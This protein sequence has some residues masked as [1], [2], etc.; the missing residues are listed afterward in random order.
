MESYEAITVLL[1]YAYKEMKMIGMLETESVDD[2]ASVWLIVI[3]RDNPTHGQYGATAK[4]LHLFTHISN[5]HIA[6]FTAAICVCIFRRT[7]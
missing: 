6:S 3:V 4:L 7:V 2:A 5:S 1:S